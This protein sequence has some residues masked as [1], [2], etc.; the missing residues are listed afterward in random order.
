LKEVDRQQQSGD[1][2]SIETDQASLFASKICTSP[3]TRH[4]G[5]GGAYRLRPGFHLPPLLLT[6]EEAFALSLGLRALRQIGLSAFAPATESALA[7]PGRV[8]SNIRCARAASELSNM[9]WPSSP[10]LGGLHIRRVPD[11]RRIGHSHR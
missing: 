9:W 6:D 10:A 4:Q 7:K 11:P 8:L 5:V 2:G 3:L 1:V